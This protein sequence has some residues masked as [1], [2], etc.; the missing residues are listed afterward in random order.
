VRFGSADQDQL[1]TAFATLRQVIH[2]HPGETR[3]ILHI[4]AGGGRSQRME[5]RLGVAYDGELVSALERQLGSGL[6][7]LALHD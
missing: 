6:V 5:L 7:D 1:L 4:P 2:Q 3:V